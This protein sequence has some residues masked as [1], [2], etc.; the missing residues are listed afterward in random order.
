[1]DFFQIPSIFC[2]T[3]TARFPERGEHLSVLAGRVNRFFEFSVSPPAPP[4][5]AAP[6]A[7]FSQAVPLMVSPVFQPA[8][9]QLR[10]GETNGI[11]AKV[12]GFF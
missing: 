10:G 4:F 9:F 1:M 5:P 11:A 12:N 8:L 3:L 2:F 6:A 7:L